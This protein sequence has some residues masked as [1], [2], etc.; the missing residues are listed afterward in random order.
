RLAFG[1]YLTDRLEAGFKEEWIIA[2][3]FF[4]ETVAYSERNAHNIISKSNIGIAY[5]NLADLYSKG[6]EPIDEK[7]MLIN[8][9]KAT[10]IAQKYN[11][12]IIYR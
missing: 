3:N 8:L 5:I 7:A 12:K 2:L 9:K 6:P 4:K 1:G 10:E 11:V